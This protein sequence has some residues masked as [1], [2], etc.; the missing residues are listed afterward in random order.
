MRNLLAIHSSNNL[1]AEL[2]LIQSSQHPFTAISSPNQIYHK[3]LGE[4]K[5]I[6][7]TISHTCSTYRAHLFVREDVWL[8]LIKAHLIRQLWS[9]RQDAGGLQRWIIYCQRKQEVLKKTTNV[10][11]QGFPICRTTGDCRAFLLH[12]QGDH[13]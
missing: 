13:K 10:S 2:H 8:Y 9:K 4:H 1:T 3:N 7:K 5:Y 11:K 12:R 6:P